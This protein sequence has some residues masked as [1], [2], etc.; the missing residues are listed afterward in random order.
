MSKNIETMLQRVGAEKC[1][2]I[3]HSFTGVDAR[4]AISLYGAHKNVTSLSTIC[5]PH[6]GLR[7]I[8]YGIGKSWRGDLRRMTRMFEVLGISKGA[9]IEFSTPG[10]KDFNLVCEDAENVQYYSVGAKKNGSIMTKALMPGFDL[11]TNKE[12]GD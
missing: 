3:A 11:I 10:M 8:D 1:H 5:S 7:T 9:A 12:F 6:L 4:A 2:L